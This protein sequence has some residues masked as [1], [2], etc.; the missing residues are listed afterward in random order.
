[1]L[2]NGIASAGRVG[3][4]Y[5]YFTEFYPKKYQSAIG[6]VFSCWEGF[7]WCVI[8]FYFLYITKSWV[9]LIIWAAASNFFAFSVCLYWMPES[10]K[11]LYEK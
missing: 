4:G 8:V 3:T 7:T 5:T 11:W 9:P 1:M 10:P 2:I 6:T